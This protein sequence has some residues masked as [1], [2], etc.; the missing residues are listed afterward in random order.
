MKSVK[1]ELTYLIKL[2]IC[3]G[4]KYPKVKQLFNFAVSDGSL[5][6]VKYLLQKYKIINI[7][8]DHL[9][10]ASGNG[11]LKILQFL[12]TKIKTDYEKIIL[13][14]FYEGHIHI[15]RYILYK[16][17]SLKVLNN[18]L[19]D[20][21]DYINNH[22]VNY[23]NPYLKHKSFYLYTKMTSLIKTKIHVENVLLPHDLK[24]IVFDYL[25]D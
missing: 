23:K 12:L 22:N 5:N 13:V 17:I 19:I 14:A 20:L 9:E 21:S 24:N 11:K 10:T 18:C 3:L 1:E 8:E 2:Y 15:I 4:D 25:K 6:I 16:N 7:T